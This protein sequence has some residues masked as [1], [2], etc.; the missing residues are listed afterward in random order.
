ME[1]GQPKTYFI[2]ALEFDTKANVIYNEFELEYGNYVVE[3]TTYCANVYAEFNEIKVNKI[4]FTVE[5]PEGQS[6][7]GISEIAVLGR[8]A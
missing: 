7:V 2:R 6:E 1:N 5:I 8:T 4:R 3:S